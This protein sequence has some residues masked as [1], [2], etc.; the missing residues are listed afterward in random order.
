MADK[1]DPV[2]QEE[3]ISDEKANESL[4][5]DISK[6]T[7]QQLMDLKDKLAEIEDEEEH[8][9]TGT[10]GISDSIHV[11]AERPGNAKAFAMRDYLATR[12]RVTFLIPRKEGEPANIV[13]TV[14]MNGWRFNI[15]KGEY[16]DIP[17]DVADILKASYAHTMNDN[18]QFLVNNIG[19]KTDEVTGAPK[20]PSQLS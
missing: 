4:A 14:I 13:E 9:V 17:I 7:H 18:Q 16:V 15:K 20:D 10:S 2:E 3:L 8:P 6:L 5:I 12:P 1:K 11:I 19:R